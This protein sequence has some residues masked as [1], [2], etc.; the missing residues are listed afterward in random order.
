MPN[1]E[2]G[3]K[4][5][6]K[7][8]VNLDEIKDADVFALNPLYRL[9]NEHDGVKVYG[10]EMQQSDYT[11]RHSWGITLSL[12]DGKRTIEDI[13]KIVIP[14]VPN[15]K[16]EKNIEAAKRYVKYLTCYFRKSTAERRNDFSSSTSNDFPAGSAHPNDRPS[17][18]VL[19]PLS[20]LP[21]FGHVPKPNYNPKVFLPK[22]AFT[23]GK[24]DSTPRRAR[25]PYN[26]T[27]H[28]TPECATNCQYCYLL[29]RNMK[30]SELLSKKRLLE[31]IKEAHEIGVFSLLMGGGDVLL[32]PHL[33]E[34]LEALTDYQFLP[35]ALATKTFLSKEMAKRLAEYGIVWEIQFSIDSTVDEVADYLVRKTG[36]C[37]GIL[38]SIDNALEAGLRVNSKSVITPYNI[39]T[40]PRLYRE[41]RHKGVGTVRLATYCRSGYHHTDDLYNHNESFKWLQKEVEKLREE[42][43]TDF[44]NIQNGSPQHEPLSKEVLQKMWGERSA[45]T[46]GRTS[47]MICADG[48]VIPCEQMPETD[49]NFCGD[50]KI[51]SLQEVWDSKELLEKTIY[52]PKE[53]FKGTPCYDCEEREECH[54]NMGYCFRDTAQYYGSIYKPATNC[55]KFNL[56]YIRRM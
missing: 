25:A 49:E 31:I 56:P 51:N 16:N 10:W 30:P 27:W 8:T 3:Q 37:K 11:I 6:V 24:Y 14:F 17:E 42:F 39:L 29:R 22:H 36:F 35:L 48:K 45:C 40:I 23:L 20:L 47:I 34:V 7:I 54:I 28:L 55:P 38:Q 41:L 44:I 13:S 43:P 33:F 1:T 4:E 5:D 15:T 9:R 12:F 53:N 19:I 2:V 18:A 52:L 50:L 21:E 46:A 26:I 32:Y